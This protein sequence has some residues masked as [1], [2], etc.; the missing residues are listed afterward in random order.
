LNFVGNLDILA[1]FHALDPFCHKHGQ[2]NQDHEKQGPK[3]KKR[4]G[5]ET[6]ARVLLVNDA[7]CLPHHGIDLDQV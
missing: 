1:G 3:A 7:L 4:S 6:A 2:T 5:Q